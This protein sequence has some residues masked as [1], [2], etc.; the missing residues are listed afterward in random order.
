M[1]MHGHGAHDD[2]SYVPEAMRRSGP[3]ATRSS[4]TP[5]GWSAEHGFSADEVDSIRGEVKA[6][7]D[8]CAQ[9]ALASP[10]PDPADGDRRRVRRRRHPA[11]RRP[12]AVVAL[13]ERRRAERSA[14]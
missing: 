4:A 12:G 8:E 14:A 11:R 7:V 5:S 13:G 2:M 9:T 1:R 3:T 6:Y 10:M